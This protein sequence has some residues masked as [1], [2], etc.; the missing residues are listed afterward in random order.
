MRD[1][2]EKEKE[3]SIF[4]IH[5]KSYMEKEYTNYF[6]AFKEDLRTIKSVSIVIVL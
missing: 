4:K 3:D 5:K 1:N 6:I 2:E